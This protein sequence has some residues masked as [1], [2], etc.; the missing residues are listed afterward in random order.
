METT[1]ENTK[2]LGKAHPKQTL[3]HTSKVINVLLNVE[4]VVFLIS[5]VF[6]HI[7]LRIR[8]LTVRIMSHKLLC[9]LVCYCVS[10]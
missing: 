2:R 10:V 7:L 5:A 1:N 9:G 8:T 4:C 6:I 3:K